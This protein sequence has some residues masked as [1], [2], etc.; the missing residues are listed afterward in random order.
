MGSPDLR[1]EA[2]TENS[3]ETDAD[4]E[5]GNR[6]NFG[7]ETLEERLIYGAI[8]GTWG[9]WLAGL[10][11][12]VGPALGYILLLILAARILGLGATRFELRLPPR[13]VCAWIGGMFAMAVALILAHI[14]FNLGLPSLA[15][16]FVGWM[17]GWIVDC[18][19]SARSLRDDFRARS[20]LGTP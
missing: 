9:F 15:K 6:R 11:Y 4:V 2:G 12:I 5:P 7:P 14:D 10:L 18:A 19:M 13:A 1:P 20:R 8:V 16:S 3:S 17:K